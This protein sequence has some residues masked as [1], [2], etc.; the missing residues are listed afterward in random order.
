MMKETVSGVEAGVVPKTVAP[1]SE[2]TSTPW[3]TGTMAPP[4]V[5]AAPAEVD[6]SGR[7]TAVTPERD[8]D[9]DA[10]SCRAE[11]VPPLLRGTRDAPAPAPGSVTGSARD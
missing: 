8:A 3:A 4:A 5:V 2:P 1:G 11:H 6:A 7:A 9:Q 10:T